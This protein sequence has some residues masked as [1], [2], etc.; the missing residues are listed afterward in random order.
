MSL[1]LNRNDIG[2]ARAVAVIASPS[3]EDLLNFGSGYPTNTPARGIA[4]TGSGVTITDVNGNAEALPD[5]GASY[6]FLPVQ[7]TAVTGGSGVIVLW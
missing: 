1:P 7:I 6:F 3:S 5:V 2:P 4:W